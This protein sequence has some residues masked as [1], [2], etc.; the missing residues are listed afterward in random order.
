MGYLVSSFDSSQ[1]LQ[2]ISRPCKDE[3]LYLV[4]P[5]ASQQMVTIRGNVLRE[6]M[7]KGDIF[8]KPCL[9][10]RKDGGTEQEKSMRPDSSLPQAAKYPGFMN[11][12]LCIADAGFESSFCSP[13]PWSVHVLLSLVPQ[14]REMAQLMGKKP[15]LMNNKSLLAGFLYFGVGLVL[16]QTATQNC[17]PS[18]ESCSACDFTCEDVTP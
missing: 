2:N 15:N 4:N 1:K 10:D 17:Q 7:L 12:R 18:M 16:C 13:S 11:L 8:E 6:S 9:Q 14:S 5:K 3:T